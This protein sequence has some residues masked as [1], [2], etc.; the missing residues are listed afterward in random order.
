MIEYINNNNNKKK[1]KNAF[2]SWLVDFRDFLEFRVL[3]PR[4]KFTH[5]TLL[6]VFALF[7]Q[8]DKYRRP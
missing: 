4:A 5:Q 7:D 2:A 8:L 3:Q 6:C 1:T